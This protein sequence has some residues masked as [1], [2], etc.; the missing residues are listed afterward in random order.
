MITKIYRLL[1]TTQEVA[2]FDWIISNFLILHRCFTIQLDKRSFMYFHIKVYQQNFKL[3]I[4]IQFSESNY[5]HF[6]S[7]EKKKEEKSYRKTS[8]LQFLL[9][10]DK[11]WVLD[12]L[13]YFDGC[14][15]PKIFPDRHLSFFEFWFPYNFKICIPLIVILWARK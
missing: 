11:K 12:H 9:S 3:R 5:Y 13:Q 8:C 4:R 10:V 7:L 1:A 14:K 15:R 2:S 6:C